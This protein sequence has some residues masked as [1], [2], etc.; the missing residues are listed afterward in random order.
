MDSTE[1]SRALG[2]NAS[3]LLSRVIESGREE[4]YR[5]LAVFA[6]APVNS[7][8]SVMQ[9]RVAREPKKLF[10]KHRC[11]LLAILNSENF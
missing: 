7:T 8:V 1:S 11:M 10:L 9:P 6:H 5:C 2:I 3:I 4:S